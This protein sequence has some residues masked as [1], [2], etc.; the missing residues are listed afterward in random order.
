[1]APPSSI[2]DVLS[3]L[4]SMVDSAIGVASP[5]GYFAALYE[6][7]TL[8]IKRAILANAFDDGP[9]MGR[10][11]CTFAG[12][13][14]DAW[15]QHQ[16]GEATTQSWALAFSA[17][18]NPQALVVQH[19]LLGIN[20]HINLDLGVA[21]ATVAPGPAIAAMRP[22]FDKINS[23]LARLV[24][25]VQMALGEVSPRF[26]TIQAVESVEDKLF[27]FTLDVAREGAWAFAQQLAAMPPA[28]WPDAIVA[29]DQEIVAVGR[30]ILDPGPLA[31]PVVKWIRDAE[32][33]DVRQNIQIVGA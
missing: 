11:D 14:L 31:S 24:G 17:L 5:V 8:G 30:A 10:L 26:R 13:F 1:M 33:S 32:S 23:I 27:D 29:R 15:A 20:A 6:R 3:G 19:L 16:R 4:D 22:D 25:A 7:V 2:D 21:V 9:R 18:G 12:R 28:R